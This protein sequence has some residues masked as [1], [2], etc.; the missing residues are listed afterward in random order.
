MPSD[1]QLV[2]L[3]N[4]ALLALNQANMTGNYTV[5]RDLGAPTFQQMNSPTRLAEI[6]S[7]LRTR[8]LDLSPIVL[9]QVKLLRAPEMNAQGMIRVVGFFTTE[10]ERVN[11]DLIFQPVHEKWRLFG[12]AVRTTPAPKRAATPPAKEAPG[13]SDAEAEPQ[14]P[15]AASEKASAPS[16][17]PKEKPKATKNAESPAPEATR[18]DVRDRLDTPPPAPA[19]EKPKKK[20]GWN[21]FGR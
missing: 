11:F 5:L 4:S 12:I 21:P 19:P 1:D 9:Y 8:K 2:I 18:G 10:P 20:G 7:V 17:K 15:V 14:S 16:A 13:A 6:F 3:I